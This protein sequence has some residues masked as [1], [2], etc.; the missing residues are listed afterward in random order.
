GG[1]AE[2]EPEPEPTPSAGGGGGGGG[3]AGAGRV[4]EVVVTGFEV[5]PTFISEELTGDETIKKTITITNIDTKKLDIKIDFSGAT[6]F[7]ITPD[8]IEELEIELDPGEEHSV[9]IILFGFDLEKSGI[10]GGNIIVSGDG[11]ESKI[12]II[13]EY[14]SEKPI[15]DVDVNVLE[16]YKEVF[17]GEEVFAEITLLNLKNVGNANVNVDYFIKDSEGKTIVSGSTIVA[18]QTQTS[19]VR[20]LT[21][22]INTRDGTY[23]FSAEAT[24]DGIVGIGSDVFKVIEK[25][26]VTK[27]Q[28]CVPISLILLIILVVLILLR[29]K[30]IKNKKIYK[31]ILTSRIKTIII[32]GLATFIVLLLNTSIREAV[33]RIFYAIISPSV[34]FKENYLIWFLLLVMLAIL[35]YLLNEI[36][37]YHHKKEPEKAK[38][39]M[40]IT[41]ENKKS[42]SKQTISKKVFGLFHDLGLVKTE[43][44]KKELENRRQK[45]KQQKEIERKEKE[46]EKRRKELE[47]AM[48]EKAEQQKKDEEL[49]RRE[50]EKQKDEEMKRKLEEKQRLKKIKEK[51]ELVDKEDHKATLKTYGGKAKV[52][53]KKKRSGILE[54]VDVF[55]L[56][57]TKMRPGK[58]KVELVDKEGRKA[59]LQVYESKNTKTSEKE[60]KAKTTEKKKRLGTLEVVDEPPEEESNKEKRKWFW[61]K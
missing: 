37:K 29:R 26:A 31:Q 25:P 21:L 19:V 48:Q 9:D 43:Q 40:V 15:F 14:E 23:I 34:C 1:G 7:V 28:F 57:R 39:F 58:A 36:N 12:S 45:A 4:P 27:G 52:T 17:D 32:L 60:Q 13:L 49:K 5:S 47:N 53:Q 59:A 8:G 51:V 33:L 24:F 11:I 16:D 38:P 20:S 22:P 6:D 30:E 55:E 56:L 3:G 61:E 2:P 41:K 42:I 50:K 54:V 18:V 35:I 44:E 10:Y 46:S